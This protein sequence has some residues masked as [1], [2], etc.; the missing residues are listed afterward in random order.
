MAPVELARSFD[1]LLTARGVDHEY[2]EIDAG[3][4]FYDWLPVIQY[5]SDHLVAE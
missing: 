5:L 2:V 1:R 3:H 4:C